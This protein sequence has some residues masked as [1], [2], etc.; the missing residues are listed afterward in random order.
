MKPCR[1]CNAAL[2]N[3]AEACQ[4]CGRLQI[5]EAPD[6][7]GPRSDML[8]KPRRS[9]WYY[10]DPAICCFFGILGASIGGYFFGLFGALVGAFV[11]LALPG[12]LKHIL[13]VS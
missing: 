1:F 11:G 5:N 6:S 12:I 4:S 8:R 3:N 2:E 9:Q 7:V 10:S 13:M